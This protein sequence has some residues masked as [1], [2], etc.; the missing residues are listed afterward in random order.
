MTEKPRYWDSW[1]GRILRAVILD[2][3]VLWDEV[4][5]KSG[6]EHRQMYR[7]VGELQKKQLIEYSQD[8]TFRVVDDGIRRAYEAFSEDRAPQSHEVL[9]EHTGWI[10]GWVENNQESNASLDNLHFFLDGRWLPEFTRKLVDRARSS[11]LAVN[12]FVD[13]EM[14]GACLRDA[15]KRGIDVLLITKRP[16]H[17][18]GRWRFH[19]S[20]VSENVSLFYSGKEKTGGGVHSKVLVVDDQVAIAS[21]MNFTLYSESSNYETGIV[22]LDRDVVESARESILSIRDENETQFANPL[23]LNG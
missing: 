16:M 5:Q 9:E 13:K 17:N 19:E 12:P 3:A 8:K 10:Q 7:A 4:K 23:H 2:D 21:S 20:L 22:T 6:L 1:K 18:P 15:A 14:I 11:I